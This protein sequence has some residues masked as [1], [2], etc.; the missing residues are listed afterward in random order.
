MVVGLP[1]PAAVPLRI[2]RKQKED[3]WGEGKEKGKSKGIFFFS[4][5]CIYSKK[6]ALGKMSRR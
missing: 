6:Q 4:H 1:K 5:E 3:E 2:L